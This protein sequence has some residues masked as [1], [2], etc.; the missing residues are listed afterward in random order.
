MK[1][2]FSI[3]ITLLFAITIIIGCE[4]K[5][6]IQVNENSKEIKVIIPD[7]LT[8]IASAKLIKENKEISKGYNV[9]YSIEKTPENIVSQ[10][11]KGD[12]DIAIVPSNIAATQYNKGA[13]YKIAATVGWGSMYLI[14]T[15][16]NKKIEELKNQEIYNIGKG[17]TPDLIAR[18]LLKDNGVDA[19]KDVNFSYV[20]GVTELA[21]IIIAGKTNYAIVPEPVLA[22]VQAKNKNVTILANLNDEWKKVNSSEYG[23]P[24]STVIVKSDLIKEDKEFLQK[25]LEELKESTTFAKDKDN[26]L[27]DYCE[28]V[29]VSA[30]KDIVKKAMD[31]ANINYIEIEKCYKE[32]ETYF[33]KLNELNSSS[34][35]GKVPN[36]DVYME[37]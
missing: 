13:N 21:P 30:N 15:Q 8:A 35:G 19:D 12:V 34:I 17:L 18:S 1:K 11:L 26:N 5:K 6:D 28:E 29:G 14:S 22:Q 33:N 32:Y 9:N 10:V 16:G 27:P 7:G 2:V 20:N 25:F 24:Q 3:L 37:K 36:E 4:T 31:N 23:Y